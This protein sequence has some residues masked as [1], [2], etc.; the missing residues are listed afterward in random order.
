MTAKHAAA[1]DIIKRCIGEKGIWASTDRYEDTCWT[2]DACLTVIP[3]LLENA[4]DKKDSDIRIVVTHLVNIQQRQLPNGKVPILFLDNAE[5]F[6]KK[7]RDK[8][9]LTGK[10]SFMLKRYEEKSLED[11]T[12]HTRDSELLYII[13]VSSVLKA[14]PKLECGEILKKSAERALEYVEKFILGENGLVMGADWRDTREDLNDKC[15][16]TNGC[17]LKE[18]Y[19]VMGREEKE[20]KTVENLRKFWNGAYFDDYV[21]NSCFDVLGN[22][23]AILYDVASPGQMESI[24][25][26]ACG[27][28]T[29]FGIKMTEVF[30][31]ALSE[32][33]QLIMEKDRAVVWP[34]VSGFMLFAMVQKGGR[35]TKWFEV[36]G[37]E[38]AKWCLLDGFYEWYSVSGGEGFGSLNQV[39]SAA[40]FLR[41]SRVLHLGEETYEHG[42]A[43]SAE[44]SV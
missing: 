28:V 34:F 33:E 30:L 38:F 9:A 15:V 42:A 37:K 14:V 23:L 26:H 29:P 40:M 1:L 20:G 35:S 25:T 2:R 19:R 31:P 22:A 10:P 18:V 8:F 24:F 44:A 32:K 13:A 43:A 12:P 11:L 3:W 16:L 36:A 4:S 17:L 41:L 5:R 27:L 6:V 7:K 39:W 21:G